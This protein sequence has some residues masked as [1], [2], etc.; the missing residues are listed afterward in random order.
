MATFIPPVPS[1]SIG[2]DSERLVYLALQVLPDEYRVLHSF[3]WLRPNRSLA[4]EPLREGEADFLILHP[5]KGLLV[6]EVKGGHPQLEGQV[7]TRGGKELRNPFQQARR[8]RYAL[9][10]AVEER[11]QRR[12]TRSMFTHG[13]LV[14]FPH[15][16]FEG[17]LPLD[18]EP[19]MIVDQLGLDKIL[20][21][22]ECAFE[23]WQ[24]A[25]V[26]ITFD[27]FRVL[28]D[29]LLPKLRLIRC[30]GSEI[31]LEREKLVQLT[32]QQQ[33]VLMGLMASPRVHVS[34]VA[35]SGKTLLALEF[36]TALAV[37]GQR[38]LLLC[39]NRHLASWLCE[40]VQHRPGNEHVKVSTFHSFAFSLA[41]RAGVEMEDPGEGNSEFWDAE[42]PMILEQALDALRRRGEPEVYDAVVIDEAQ[43]FFRDWWVTVESL[44]AGGR[45]GRLYAFSDLKQSLRR[46]PEPPPV[47]F[48]TTFDLRINCRNTSSIGRSAA[49][50]ADI[51]FV[52]L[53]GAPEG[54]PPRALRSR[55]EEEARGLLLREVQALMARHTLKAEQV[56]IIGPTTLERSGLLSAASRQDLR[57]TSDLAAWRRGGGILVTTARAFKG[58][59]ADVIFIYGLSGFSGLFSRTDLY[60]AWTRARHR[61][62]L[63]CH[64][65]EVRQEI[66]AVLSCSPPTLGPG[67][68]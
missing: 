42:V 7:W 64:G 31:A 8:N 28:L 56:A 58:L 44:T 24:K 15:S 54:E 14:V 62:F 53:P 40:Q 38:V 67:C 27:Q 1:E 32:V 12:V 17:N 30:V 60:V 19:R 4:S 3:P 52:E 11:T 2:V 33:A 39:Y 49:A 43:D 51:A 22:I 46:A 59:E 13:D 68:L 23:A 50:L 45:D 57:L 36:A 65:E 34:G 41:L 61:L 66:E 37:K 63:H 9:L 18:A 26:T 21:I 47:H 29:A 5:K 25:P 55:T 10:E 6:L 16:L 48:D 20:E 35:G